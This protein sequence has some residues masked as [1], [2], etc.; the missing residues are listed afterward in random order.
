MGDTIQPPTPETPWSQRNQD[1]G[2]LSLSA[3]SATDTACV[4]SPEWTFPGAQKGGRGPALSC[5]LYRQWIPAIIPG[6][7]L[8]GQSLGRSPS[9][10]LQLWEQGETGESPLACLGACGGPSCWGAEDP[11]SGAS[12]PALFSLT[13]ILPA[14]ALCLH[15]ATSFSEQAYDKVIM[16]SNLTGGQLTLSPDVTPNSIYY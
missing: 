7:G 10:S 15:P 12:P 13:F 9:K 3:A 6:Q 5:A 1:S 2:H 14:S 16:T 11:T 8:C 4:P